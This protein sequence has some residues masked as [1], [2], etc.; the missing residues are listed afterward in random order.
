M[1]TPDCVQVRAPGWYEHLLLDPDYKVQPEK[2]LNLI[3]CSN[4]NETTG[5]NPGLPIQNFMNL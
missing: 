4:V 2:G 1:I 5:L 3:I